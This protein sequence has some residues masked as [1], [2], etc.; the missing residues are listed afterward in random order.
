M[1][2]ENARFPNAA[3]VAPDA[4]FKPLEGEVV[5]PEAPTMPGFVKK[6]PKPKKPRKVQLT[7]SPHLLRLNDASLASVIDRLDVPVLLC[8]SAPWCIPCKQISVYIIALAHEFA[9]KAAIAIVDLDEAPMAAQRFSI[10]AV[11][12]TLIFH[13]GQQVARFI[14]GNTSVPKLRSLI[15]HAHEKAEKASQEGVLE[16]DP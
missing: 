11:P 12:T 2:N 3:P 15:R 4:G 14:G 10:Q 13:Q 5:R 6:P 7:E 1:S 16:G 8:F 9:D